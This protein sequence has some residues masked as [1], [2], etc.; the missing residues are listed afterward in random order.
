[1]IVGTMKFT[2]F[3]SLVWIVFVSAVGL[4]AATKPNV[5]FIAVDD[6][7]PELG[8]YG[9]EHIKTPHIDQLAKGS[10]TFTR[11]Y[12][13]QAVCNPS[14]A[15]LMTGLRP[16]ATKVWDLVTHFRNTVPNVVTLPQQF[17]KHGYHA[18]AYGKIFHNPLPDDKSWDEPNHWATKA[19]VWS[20]RSRLR[21]IDYRKKMKADGKSEAAIKR[22]RAPAT[23]DEDVPDIAR[24]DGEMTNLAIGALKKLA[25]KDQPFFL[26]VG[27]IKPHLPFNPPKRYW[28][29]Y[30]PA[31][32]P[33]AANVKLPIDAPA[34]A[35]NTMYELR[36]Y[37][38]FAQT[39]SPDRGALSEQQ[40]R[41]LKH[42]YYASV[43]FVDAQ[44]GRLMGELDRLKLRDD[45]IVVLW[46]DHGWKLGE[47]RSWCKQT[48]YEIDAR[49]P[50]IVHAPKAKGNGKQCETPVELIDLFP[51]LCELAG[52][53]SPQHLQGKSLSALLDEPESNWPTVAFSQFRRRRGGAEY[54]GYAMRTERYRYVEWLNRADGKTAAVELYD[55]ASDPQE[56]RNVASVQTVQVKRLAAEMWRTIPRPTPGKRSRPIITFRNDSDETVEVCWLAPDGRRLTQ[57]RIEPRKSRN[58][59]T[60]LS[61]RFAV[62]IKGKGDV[63]T[64]TVTKQQQT[65]SIKGQSGARIRR[66]NVLVLMGDDWSWPHAGFLDDKTIRTPTFDRLAREGVVFDHAFV[67]SPSCTPSRL[68]VASGQWHW[69]LGEGA[70]LGGSLAADVPVYPGLLKASGYQIGFSR[71]GAAP[72]KNVY[73]KTD[74]FGPRFESFEK[75]INDRDDDR[76]FCFWYGAGEP[77]RP[78]RA[79]TGVKKGLDPKSVEV[80]ACLPDNETVRSDLCD[81]YERVQRFDT[82][83]ARMLQRLKA[84]GELDNTIII[85][86]G[87]NGMPFPRCKATLYDQGTRVPLV[88]RWP[89]RVPAGRTVKDFVSLTDL[90]PTILEL[91]GIKV[92]NQMTGRSLRDALESKRSGLID[93][94]R[95]FTLTGMERH[96]YP[97]P[98]RAIRMRD[99]LYIRNFNPDKWPDGQSKKP[100]PT[101]NFKDG[102]WPNF[103][104]AF[105]FNIDPSPTK[106]FL[107]DH[108]KEADVKPFFELACGRRPN[109]ELYELK[110]DPQQIRNVVDD[111]RFAKQ[112]AQLRSKLESELQQSSDPRLKKAAASRR[113]NVLMISVDDLN[114]WIGCLGGHPQT[115]TPNIDRLAASG[116]L[117][118]NAYCPAAS[119]NPS[120]TAIMTG[121]S[122]QRSG[123]LRNGQKMREVLPDAEI[124]PKYFSRH[125]YFSAG[126][127]K[128]LHYFIDAPSWEDY[129]PDKA[130]EN[131]FPRTLYPKKRPVSIPHA[132][133]WMYRETDWGPLDATDEEFG[134][135]WLVSKWIG[136]QLARKHDRPFFLACGIY[137]PHEP[138][139][140]P[141][142]YFDMFPLDQ[143]KL[144]VGYKA[145]DLDDVP[146]QGQRLGRNRYFAHIR[147]HKQWR[148]GVQ[149]YLASIAF[150]DAM[151]GRVISAL[152]KSSHR[153]NTIVVLWSDH[154]WHLGEK[155]HWQ[156]FTGWRACAR[157]PL[158][159]RAPGVSAAKCERTVS[160]QSL[161]VTLNEMCG[162]PAKKGIDGRSLV[163]LLR[164]PKAKWSHAVMTQLDWPGNYAISTQRWRY[165]HY[166][167]GGEELYDIVSDPFEWKNLAADPEQAERLEEFR[168]RGVKVGA[169]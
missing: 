34:M 58:I 50:L 96:V 132:G 26:A 85:L 75:F 24:P 105:S 121:L 81:Y 90:A 9:N 31:K 62:Q 110:S 104:G 21:L 103:P 60:T 155:E 162:L 39:P 134:G 151:V 33:L 130:K 145:D 1:M 38:D 106:Q 87:D 138:W 13:Q 91:T 6:L 93:E 148:Q 156:K 18:V 10:V 143:V 23:E 117:F 135:D 124:M 44:L 101:I 84:I 144:P 53:E 3:L 123:L 63:Q 77:H 70:N 80:P 2:Q 56:N 65:I 79:G 48:N 82:D 163:P 149:G 43:S 32:L 128:I 7:R 42:G 49:V 73:R 112:L 141:K 109:E 127:G 136:E 41:R 102:S 57:G 67:S 129:F 88:V 37:M 17:R 28:D 165:I 95:T 160:L 125:G 157:V 74:P 161:F 54:M 142:K 76:P 98:S 167:K 4:N 140:V 159:I 51:T 25:K 22:M 11:A 147:E 12:C 61:H 126:S 64:V 150:A 107:L 139:F 19:R 169:R 97:Y 119:C 83:A 154:G 168:A 14:R 94:Q 20:N 71:K 89:K 99:F 16:D 36:D 131:P 92:P 66:P 69:R 114:D 164:D 153:D 120:R 52:V 122:P 115:K 29:L 68:A 116:V 35:M 100:A 133:K 118:T 137:R 158:I 55:H 78:Y 47:H 40:Q 111:P 152:E 8:C 30:D 72:S 146:P 166:A 45:T 108:R 46:G 59:G 86:A 27:Y 113:P 15:S 5:L